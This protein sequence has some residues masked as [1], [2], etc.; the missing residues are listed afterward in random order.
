MPSLDS[1][2]PEIMAEITQYLD[3]PSHTT[4]RYLSRTINALTGRAPIMSEADF[5]KVNKV[6][7]G[8]FSRKDYP[9]LEFLCVEC[10]EFLPRDSFQDS[11]AK[12][13]CEGPRLCM[14]C[15]ARK[16]LYDKAGFVYK[17]VKSF[18]CASC[19]EI[20]PLIKEGSYVQVRAEGRRVKKIDTGGKRWCGLCWV[21]IKAW[22]GCHGPR[23]PEF[24]VQRYGLD[25]GLRYN[26]HGVQI[27]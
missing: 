3:P 24:L 22:E 14:S 4:L 10:M 6:F 17:G 2:P 9:K 27:P 19:H 11:K 5:A 23:A 13:K 8:Q 7:E 18:W 12:N 1:I 26:I 15:S 25:R 16:C 21:A 20:S